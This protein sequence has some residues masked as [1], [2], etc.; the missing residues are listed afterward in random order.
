V[1]TLKQFF[2]IIVFFHVTCIG[3][4]FFRAGG[5]PHGVRQWPVVKSYLEAMFHLPGTIPFTGFVLPVVLLGGL[6][7]FFQSQNDRMNE[8]S[9][10]PTTRKGTAVSAALAA[11]TLLGVFEGA[12]FIYFQF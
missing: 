12:Q 1:G 5:L 9:Q 10:W 11:I 2:L 8:F 3:W 7:L 4:L 6:A